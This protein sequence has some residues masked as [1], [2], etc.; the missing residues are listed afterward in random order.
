MRLRSTK[1]R[2]RS[3]PAA[4]L[5]DELRRARTLTVKVTEFAVRRWIGLRGHEA[6]VLLRHCLRERA[7]TPGAK[8][9]FAAILER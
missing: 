2:A 3:R 7:T 1:A 5:A 6:G 8:F 4:D 9:V